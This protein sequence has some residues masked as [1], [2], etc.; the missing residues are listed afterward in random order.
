VQV[1]NEI[2]GATQFAHFRKGDV[3]FRAG[4]IP[5]G[6]YTVVSGALES[7]IHNSAESRDYVRV[8][9]SGEHWGE[10]ILT[11]NWETVGLLTALED[12]R[13]LIL[14][15]NDFTNLRSALPVL[16]DYFNR[17]SEEVYAHTLRQSAPP[18]LESK[19]PG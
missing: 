12:T 13:V 1:R 2:K 16:D 19:P 6:F 10:R 5:D 14:K 17:I 4:Q 15:K 8:I 3:L 18:D 7:R 9:G 11:G